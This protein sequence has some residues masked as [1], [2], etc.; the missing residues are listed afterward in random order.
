VQLAARRGDEAKLLALAQA[1][2]DQ[3]DMTG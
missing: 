2:A 3:Q 1:M